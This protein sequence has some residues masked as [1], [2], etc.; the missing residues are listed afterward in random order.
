MSVVECQTD[1]FIDSACTS[2]VAALEN[3]P[4]YRSIAV[5][6]SSD[7][8]QRRA[9]LTHYFAYS[10]QEGS[11]IGR[12][13][14]LPE[15]HVGVAVWLLPQPPEVQKR[16]ALCKQKF[17]RETLGQ[18]GSLNYNRI[19]EYMSRRAQPL[20]GPDSWYLSIVAVAPDAHG[21]GLGTRLLAPTLAEADRAGAVCYLETFSIRNLA[22][23]ERQAFA[24]KARF[25]EPTTQA[26]Y[27]IMVRDP[28]RRSK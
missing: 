25:K 20:V 15:A 7:D 12:S 28:I 10:I 19:I 11:R 18:Q 24:T 13:V 23:Y 17:L 6:S 1:L 2:A 9:V 16:E 27:A 14:H 4:F 22:F 21:Q 3:D 8:A 5:G 26:E